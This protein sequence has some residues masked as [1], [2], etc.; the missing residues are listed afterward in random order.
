[1]TLLSVVVTVVDGGAA[2]ERCLTALGNQDGA[3]DLEV[4]VPYDAS[5][6]GIQPLGARFPKVGFIPLGTITTQ[7]RWDGPAG[8]H[9]LFDRR[10]AAG[11]K[12]VSGKLVAIVEDRGVP[13]ANWARAMIDL[14]ARLPHG[15]IG[16]AIENGREALL[17]R[18][19]YICDFGRYQLPFDAGPREYVS[20]VNICYKREALLQTR[21]LWEDRY[22]ETTVHWAL[23]RAGA[24]LYLSPEPV[25]DEIRDDLTFGGL[26]RERLG[27]GRLFAYTRAREGPTWRRVLLAG[28]APLLPGVLFLRLFRQYLGKGHP[29]FRFLTAAPTILCLL[30]AWSAGEL[31]GYLT[32]KP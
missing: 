6:T 17:N 22:H 26:L 31:T 4:L 27:W 8:Q 5:V 10:R 16:G 14:H 18:A 25:V 15:V 13:R 20:D 23:L 2:L 11:L 30:A 12:A 32:G 19:V 1:M 28:L 3:P 9:E 21:A 29:P 7:R 24:T